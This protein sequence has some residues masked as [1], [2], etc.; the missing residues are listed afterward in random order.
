[1]EIA[2]ALKVIVISSGATCAG[3]AGSTAKFNIIAGIRTQNRYIL[4]RKKYIFFVFKITI[5]IYVSICTLQTFNSPKSPSNRINYE[6]LSIPI[7]SFSMTSTL[8]YASI[9]DY[10]PSQSHNNTIMAHPSSV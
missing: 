1:M 4:G 2:T 10:D 9:N 7:P 6:M 3:Q 5:N 8:E